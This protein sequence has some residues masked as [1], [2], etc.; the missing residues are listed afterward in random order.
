MNQKILAKEGRQTDSET[1][2]NNTNRTFQNNERKCK[3]VKNAEWVNIMVKESLIREEGK[4]MRR[5]TQ[6]N[7]QKH[8]DL[9]NARLWWHIMDSEW[10]K[11]F[12]SQ[13]TGYC[14]EPIYPKKWQKEKT[15]QIQK[16]PRKKNSP[17]Y[18]R[19][20]TCLTMM[21]KILTA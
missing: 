7:I 10:K 19:P 21:L 16:Y 14:L 3:L 9:E 4:S 5:F 13:L 6:S 12:H 1:E 17:S 2:S 8:T 11:Y 15:S 18:Y 20:I